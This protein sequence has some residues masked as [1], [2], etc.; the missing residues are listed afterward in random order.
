MDTGQSSQSS[1]NKRMALEPIRKWKFEVAR[2]PLVATRDIKEED[3]E[4]CIAA[5]QKTSNEVFERLN[6]EEGG[7]FV[8]DGEGSDGFREIRFSRVVGD[9]RSTPRLLLAGQTTWITFRGGDEV[10]SVPW[11]V[12]R[13]KR[14]HGVVK[15]K[16][17]LKTVPRTHPVAR[18]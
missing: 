6:R 3:I 14:L 18:R 11:T 13:A 4:T 2:L 5:L 10:P 17:R 12:G 7:F 9:V 16:L 1:R 8:P 15:E